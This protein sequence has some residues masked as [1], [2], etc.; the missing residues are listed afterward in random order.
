MNTLPK[1]I[2]EK[3][4]TRLAAP[5]F[6]PPGMQCNPSNR[7][8]L[9]QSGMEESQPPT[10]GKRK[11]IA[12]LSLALVFALG[13]SMPAFAAAPFELDGNATSNDFPGDD[14]DA[15]NSGGGTPLARTGLIVDRPEPPFAQFTGGQSK[16]EEDIPNWRHRSGTP[17]AKDDITNAYAAAYT[18][19]DTG[20][21]ILVFGMDRFDTSGDAQLGFW[22]L[23]DQVQPVAGGTFTGEHVNGDL[24]VLVNFSGGGD[25]PTIAAFRWE[26]TGLV[27]VGMAVQVLCTGGFIPDGRNA[28]GI[29]NAVTATAPWTYFNKDVGQGDTATNFPP[30]AF[31]E[32]GINLTDLGIA[33]CFTN[34]IAESRSSTSITAVLKDFATPAGGFNLCD[35]EVTKNCANPR[36]DQSGNNIIYDISGKVTNTGIGTLSNVTLSDDPTASSAFQVVDCTTNTPTGANFPLASLAGG[37]EACYLRYDNGTRG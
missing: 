36:L 10:P 33:A 23:Q 28:C 18:H 11:A 19:P 37:A 31:F 6:G 3:N 26:G 9:F 21:L 29:T 27:Q 12:A 7:R 17:P 35:I 2:E 16:D 30:A 14:W 8:A 25:V 13:M 20:D 24:L 22:F 34:F 4:C 15:V 5:L 1:M 32:G